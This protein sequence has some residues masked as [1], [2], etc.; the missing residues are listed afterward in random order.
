[1]KRWSRV[2]NPRL[3]SIHTEPFRSARRRASS[4]AQQILGATGRLCFASVV[5]REGAPG[6]LPELGHADNSVIEIKSWTSVD[7]GVF[8]M[9]LKRLE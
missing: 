5:G 6:G 3:G 1:M 4:V 8:V 7:G 2:R 9:L